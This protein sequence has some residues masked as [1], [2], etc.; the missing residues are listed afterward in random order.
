MTPME[1]VWGRPDEDREVSQING[2]DP[3]AEKSTLGHLIDILGAL[4][5]AGVF[6]LLGTYLVACL[7]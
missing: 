2:L 4:A 1:A 7:K 3:E 5:T 6:L